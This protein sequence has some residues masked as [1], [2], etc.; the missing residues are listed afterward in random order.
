MSGCWNLDWRSNWLRELNF[1][2]VCLEDIVYWDGAKALVAGSL[3]EAENFDKD[4]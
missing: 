3:T 2:A 4:W 1:D